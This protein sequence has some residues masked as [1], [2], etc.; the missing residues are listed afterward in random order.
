VIGLQTGTSFK[1]PGGQGALPK[2][3]KPHKNKE[4]N[5]YFYFFPIWQFEQ[6]SEN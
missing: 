4:V 2:F 6:L 1:K 3:G 5:F